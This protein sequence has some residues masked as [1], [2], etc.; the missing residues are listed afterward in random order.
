LLTE[1]QEITLTSQW[2]EVKKMI[3]E[4]PRYSKFSSSD[5]VCLLGYSY[6]AFRRSVISHLFRET[7]NL[8]PS[9]IWFY[10]FKFFFFLFYQMML[11]CM[12]VLF[13]CIDTFSLAV[14]P[15]KFSLKWPITCPFRA[16]SEHHRMHSCRFPGMCFCLLS[17]V[18]KRE[19]EFDDFIQERL[20]EAKGDL[21]E[22]LKET[23]LITY[24]YI[25]HT[26]VWMMGLESCIRTV[27]S[28][29]LIPNVSAPLLPH[30][31][32]YLCVRILRWLNQLK[33]LLSL[34]LT[35]GDKRW[36]WWWQVI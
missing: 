35:V 32:T 3:K 26:S 15:Y 36:H 17:L 19:R 33:L 11:L 23:K 6:H 29:S 22:L 13:I 5:R 28:S 14:W 9:D 16:L 18:Q 1:T 34:T 27:H 4:D 30:T 8:A 7:V 2:K 10:L 24:K 12:V 20:L 21:R 31:C 25:L